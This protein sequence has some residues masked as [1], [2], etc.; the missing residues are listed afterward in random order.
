MY[1]GQFWKKKPSKLGASEAVT[2]WAENLWLF[3]DWDCH[4]KNATARVNSEA[5]TAAAGNSRA[6]QAM[7]H[8]PAMP[9]GE[10]EKETA[11]KR[12]FTE[13]MAG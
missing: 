1:T 3:I 7:L 11:H 4:R 10:C 13:F 12:I 5:V 6:F 2:S 9:A 8:P